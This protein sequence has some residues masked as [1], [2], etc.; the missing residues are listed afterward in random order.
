[1]AS[2]DIH[3]KGRRRAHMTLEG[4]MASLDC[5]VWCDQLQALERNGRVP[6]VGQVVGVDAKVKKTTVVVPAGEVADEVA[7]DDSSAEHAPVTMA[8]VELIVNDLWGGDLDDEARRALFRIGV[9]AH[10]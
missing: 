2:F 9:P 4:S 6:E 3:K 10:S 8:K 1:M 7:D 5:I